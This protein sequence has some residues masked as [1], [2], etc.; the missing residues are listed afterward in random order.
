MRGNEIWRPAPNS[1]RGRDGSLLGGGSFQDSTNR[2]WRVRPP[3][4][5]LPRGGPPS[6]YAPSG[7]A[8][9]ETTGTRPVQTFSQR[10]TASNMIMAIQTIMIEVQIEST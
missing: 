10:L 8:T 1:E 9:S 6:R 4:P 3:L 2:L 7:T 5:R